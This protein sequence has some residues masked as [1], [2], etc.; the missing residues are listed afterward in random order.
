M[1]APTVLI[2]ARAPVPGEAKTRLA[3]HVGDEAAARLA[4]AALLDTIGAAASTG[5]S[6]CVAITGDLAAAPM[7]SEIAVAM[8]SHRRIDQ[9]GEC[10][11]DRLAAAHADADRGGGVVQVGMDTPHVRP[12]QLR[13]AGHALA[14]RDAVLGRAHDGGWWVLG[15]R[16]G[17]DA[18][19]LRGV[20]M[21][22]A[23]T[24]VLTRAALRGQGACVAEAP[25]LTDV[26]TWADALEV[27]ASAPR[28]RFAR[29]VAR[30]LGGGLG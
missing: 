8:A 12:T 13:T 1:T 3:A 2:V 17:R 23:R 15:V 21:S 7:C 19:C 29:V 6:V 30:L 4:G 24:G 26:D 14:W 20:P 16:D 27:A 5:W 22:T 11:A 25:W 18:A 10:F 28:T 9:R